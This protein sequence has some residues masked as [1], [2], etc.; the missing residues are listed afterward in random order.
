ME[1]FAVCIEFWRYF[2]RLVLALR[3]LVELTLE[4]I[5][6]RHLFRLVTRAIRFSPK[7]NTRTDFIY[8]LNKWYLI[9]L[10]LQSKFTLMI[11]KST[12][13]S[14][15]LTK[16]PQPN[17]LSDWANK[18]QLCFNPEKCEVMRVTHNRDWT[19]PSYPLGTQ[20]KS[21]KCAKDLGV[22]I[23]L[24]WSKHVCHI[25][26]KA[27]IVLGLIK[28]SIGNDNRHVFSSLHKSLVRPMPP[29][30]EPVLDQR[31]W[32]LGKSPKKS[33]V[34]GLKAKAWR[35]ELW[36][37]LSLTELVFSRETYKV[38]IFSSML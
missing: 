13:R 38:F 3:H 25:A 19:T 10:Q 8:H 20:L 32:I 22:T 11:P 17:R 6:G 31:H 30:M 37:P 9:K 7:N 4:R 18:W 21:V 16:E 29:R 26:S 34:V 5:L 15:S 23:S 1:A 28:R 24:S 14:V 12:E 2:H 27:N 36:R 33:L 35:N